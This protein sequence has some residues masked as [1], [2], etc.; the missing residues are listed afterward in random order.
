M[1]IILLM[2]SVFY[3][4]SPLG[5]ADLTHIRYV[6]AP[7]FIAGTFIIFRHF[8]VPLLGKLPRVNF[9]IIGGGTAGILVLFISL[10]WSQINWKE[11]YR[12][13]L[14]VSDETIVPREFRETAAFLKSSLG[15]DEYFFSMTN[16]ASWYYLVDKPCP[17]RFQIVWLA[18]PPFYQYEIIEDLKKRNVKFILYKND[19]IWM[20][21]DGISNEKKLPLLVDYIKHHYVFYKEVHKNEIWIRKAVDSQ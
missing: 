12:F 4:R 13:P 9:R 21:I 6:A 19:T 14:G 5:R 15:D 2:L 16:D 8:L 3:F 1:E 18:M 20:N 10:Y 17:A 7:I 11:F